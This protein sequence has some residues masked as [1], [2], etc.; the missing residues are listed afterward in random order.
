MKNRILIAFTSKYGST[1]EVADVIAGTLKN[2]GFEV[3]AQPIGKIRTID[4]Y[5][6]LV[7]G[8]PIYFG[9][10]H[11]DALHFVEQRRQELDGRPVA[12]FALG[13]L[14]DAADENEMQ[15]AR[16]VIE[17]GLSKHTWLSPFTIQVFGGKYDPAKLRLADRLIAALPASPLHQ[18]PACDRR[19][20][21]AIRAWAGA[22]AEQLN[23]APIQ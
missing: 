8:A 22:L 2:G 11:K 7:L 10:W 18:Q 13:P 5:R 6:S 16:A 14:G 3:D 15:Q 12:I 4:G 21:S 20:W 17:K 9:S 19:D 23:S 1:R